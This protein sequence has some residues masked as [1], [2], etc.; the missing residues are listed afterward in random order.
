MGQLRDDGFED[1][2]ARLAVH[3]V[4]QEDVD[5]QSPMVI[6]G[7]LV[8]EKQRFGAQA[9]DA[10]GHVRRHVREGTLDQRVDDLFEEA[11]TGVDDAARHFRPP[12]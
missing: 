3:G 10:A 9:E 1:G 6:A 8:V 12:G 4:G 7:Q 5:A 11:T 2:A